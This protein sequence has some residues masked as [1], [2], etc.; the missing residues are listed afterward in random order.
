VNRFKSVNDTLGHQA[1]DLLLQQVADRLRS[2][3]RRSDLV[4]RVAGDEFAVLQCG[5]SQPTSSTT[6]GR[7]LIDTLARPFELGGQLVQIGASVGVAIAPFDGEQADQLLKYAAIAL[8]RAEE[9]GRNTLRYFEP[10]MDARMKARRETELDL[11]AAVDNAQFELAFQPLVS[12]T[13][14][15]VTGVEAL[16]RWDHP[17]RGRISPADFIPLAEDTGLIIPIGRWVLRQACQMAATWP[18]SVRVAVNVSPVQFRSPSLVQDVLAA[19]DAARLPASRLELEITEAV[20]LGDSAH[21]LSLMCE[22]RGHGVRISMDD[23]GT[24]YSSLSYLRRFP[25]D[26]IKID[27]SFVEGVDTQGEA[28]AI[29]QAVKALA[30]ALGMATTVEGVETQAQLLAVQLAG[31]DEVQGFYFSRP[32]PASEIAQVILDGFPAESFPPAR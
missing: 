32:R 1:G 6:L 2:A 15:R 24:G 12:L 5:V 31:C 8:S 22:L 21:A 4:C 10:A 27:R 29:V 25:F 3:A 30:N 7:R 9:E 19:L 23:F 11:R 18:D 17:Q 13:D 14:L 28:L 16:L 26:K 20:L